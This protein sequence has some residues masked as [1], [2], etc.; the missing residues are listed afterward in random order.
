MRHFIVLP[1]L[2]L[3]AATTNPA[4]LYQQAMKQLDQ[5]REY[6]RTELDDLPATPLNE[7]TA[8]YLKE[9]EGIT[10]L[11]TDAAK[12]PG[13]QWPESG[14]DINNVLPSLNW[15]RHGAKLLMLQARMDLKNKQPADAV[16][17]GMAAIALAR[18][19]GQQKLMVS[20]LVEIGIESQAIDE[21]LA[22]LPALPPDVKKTLPAKLAALPK[23]ITAA[24]M[25]DAEFK[26]GQAS[27]NRQAALSGAGVPAAMFDAAKPFYDAVSR[28]TTQP[29]DQF[30]ATV[31]MEA[32]KLALNPFPKIMAPSL[33]RFMEQQRKI[34]VK[35]QKL[36]EACTSAAAGVSKS[37]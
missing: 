31:D 27:Q 5:P 34:E 30:D 32:T 15:A 8:A 21:M 25:L 7:K 23:S 11:L 24:E 19:I 18:N 33:K 10:K 17:H 2:A 36:Q 14:G 35:R 16:E 3:V 28:A 6:D 20:R 12:M 1:L 26:F 22:M 29:A 37:S 13:V 4:D 9:R